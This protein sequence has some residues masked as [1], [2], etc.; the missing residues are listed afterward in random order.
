[1]GASSKKKFRDRKVKSVRRD[2]FEANPKEELDLN[3]L[4]TQ[5]KLVLERDKGLFKIR[6]TVT[7]LPPKKGRFEPK[8]LKKFEMETKIEKVPLFEKEVDASV[9]PV[10]GTWG[11]GETEVDPRAERL[12]ELR[13]TIENENV[14][15][16]AGGYLVKTDFP[17]VPATVDPA[18]LRLFHVSA[19]CKVYELRKARYEYVYDENFL[20]DGNLDKKEILRTVKDQRILGEIARIIGAKDP[21]LALALLPPLFAPTTQRTT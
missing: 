19:D 1:M 14:L 16:W 3:Q 5:G 10:H 15:E 9:E 6:T 20:L 21:A 2:D 11:T 17:Y 18:N 12:D 7:I 8:K 4:K 13:R